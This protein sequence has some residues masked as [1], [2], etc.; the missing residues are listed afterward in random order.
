[1]VPHVPLNALVYRKKSNSVHTISGAGSGTANGSRYKED[2]WDAFD[3]EA[4]VHH[5]RLVMFELQ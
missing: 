5:L 3:L 1:M 2:T 4:F